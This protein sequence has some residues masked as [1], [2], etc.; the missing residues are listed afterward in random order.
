MTMTGLV[1]FLS[2]D[3]I[4]FFSETE[5]GILGSSFRR[6]PPLKALALSEGNGIESSVVVEG[7]IGL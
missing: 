1:V 4:E 5:R 3:K 6:S 7:F 2:E